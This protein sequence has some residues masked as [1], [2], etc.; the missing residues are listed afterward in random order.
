MLRGH[1]ILTVIFSA[2]L[3]MAGMV[4]GQTCG[5]VSGDFMVGFAD[6]SQVINYLFKGGT[7]TYPSMGNVDGLS[8]YSLNDAAY[9]YDYLMYMGPSPSCP[10]TGGNQP[11]STSD[12]IIIKEAII[13]S[14]ETSWDVEI[15]VH[16]N[17]DFK[18]LA[19]PLSFSCNATSFECTG[20]SYG[21]IVSLF[22]TK[23]NDY[24]N[25]EDYVVVYLHNG[26]TVSVT[27]SALVATVNFTFDITSQ[28]EFITIDT[29]QNFGGISGNDLEVSDDS[30]P[31]IPVFIAGPPDADGDGEPDET[32]NCVNVYNPAQ[33]NSDGDAYGDSCDVCITVY[34]PDQIDTDGDSYG[35]LCDNC[36]Y[37]YN[38]SQTDT[39]EDEVGDACESGAGLVVTNLTDS[40]DGTLRWA[41]EQANLNAGAD[42][43][44][45]A[46]SGTITPQTLLPFVDDSTIILGETAPGG[47]RSVII[48]ATDITSGDDQFGLN[49]NGNY[50][51]L[52]NMVIINAPDACLNVSGNYINVVGCH[53]GVTADGSDWSAGGR[54]V[55]VLGSNNHIGGIGEEDRNVIGC[56]SGSECIYIE[57]PEENNSI[58]NNFIGLAADGGEF[59]TTFEGQYGIRVGYDNNVIGQS[60]Y[61]P[62][63]IGNCNTGIYLFGIDG[64]EIANNVIGTGPDSTE[65]NPCNVGI[66]LQG[67]TNTEIGTT[68]I[69]NFITG[70]S[71]GIELTG[72][73][74]ENNRIINNVVRNATTAGVH[75]NNGVR[76]NAVGGENAGEGNLIDSCSGDGI[77]FYSNTDNDT[78]IGN[79]I[80]D[81]GSNGI[82]IDWNTDT[83]LV[84]NNTIA[85]N[86]RNGVEVGIN[87]RLVTITQN[88]IYGNDSLG[89]NLGLDG[90]TPNDPGDVD[91]GSND[92]VNFP[93]IDSVSALSDSSFII[94]GTTPGNGTVE[95]F[96]AHPAEDDTKP[97][98]PSGYGQA[99]SYIGDTV[100]TGQF[101]FAV[102]NT[103]PFY[104]V[105]SMTYT[106]ADGNT[107][108]FAPNEI[109]V[110]KPLIIVVYSPINV[111]V[112]DPNEDQY[113]R[114]ADG[115][116]VDDLPAGEGEY[117]EDPNDS[118]VINNPIQGKYRIQYF[119]ELDN[120]G[121]EEYSS[122]IK[123]DGTQQVVVVVDRQVPPP[124]D[125]DEYEYCV[126][127]GFHYEEGDANGDA[128]AN[129]A[130]ASY[131]VNFIFFGGAAPDPLM[132]ADANCDLSVNIADASFIVYA[133]FFGGA[134]PCTLSE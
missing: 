92:L 4:H 57:V 116:L 65:S 69:G 35:D 48:D 107:S 83:V 103:I 91:A 85:N 121:D 15:W 133:I 80:Q 72:T 31:V 79:I 19:V 29:L 110:P 22:L 28:D 132:S 13:P 93:E 24:D 82:Y 126:E 23:G 78:I 90:I 67:A 66:L 40:G 131:I 102:P 6:Y 63:Y 59:V 12:T 75:F 111:L 64:T 104:T 74:T 94:F 47:A 124:G 36:V 130:D 7:C 20:A 118:L 134:Q 27:D 38:P 100:A 34:D 61:S 96:M 76:L 109:M 16:G 43:I 106:D 112:T 54:G 46:V 56:G 58:V 41:I 50:C 21:N 101:L 105:V 98:D 115:T 45:F 89:I 73:G 25:T 120:T 95:F 49:L 1:F 77:N 11:T 114:L 10:P 84:A 62:N 53:L 127:E 88:E 44:T 108:E 55:Y 70:G 86:G 32:D 14:G 51:A 99:Y 8:S 119:S 117:Y 97:E 5:D 113:G 18:A 125:Y 30:G 122:I 123:T 3:L 17:L 26:S 60:S 81:N 52:S 2:I 87:T 42:V 128:S 37:V 9:I 129:I 71:F 39:D 68:D 33:E